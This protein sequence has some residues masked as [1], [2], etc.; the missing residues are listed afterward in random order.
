MK[1]KYVKPSMQVYDIKGT[2]RILQ[3]SNPGGGHFN[4][5]PGQAEDE[6]QLA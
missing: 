3:S 6:K 2:P 1:K 4:Y 5:I